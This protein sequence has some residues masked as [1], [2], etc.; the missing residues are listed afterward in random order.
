M[1]EKRYETISQSRS[2]SP[3]E[4]KTLGQWI[5]LTSH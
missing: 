5:I 2:Q 4:E 1:L 3:N